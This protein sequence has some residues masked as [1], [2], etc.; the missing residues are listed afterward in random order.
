MADEKQPLI[1]LEDDFQKEISK[2]NKRREEAKGPYDALKQ[3]IDKLRAALSEKERKMVEYLAILNDRRAEHRYDQYKAQKL[4]EIKEDKKTQVISTKETLR[5]W[6]TWIKPRHMASPAVRN[7]EKWLMD[8]VSYI[9]N[10]RVI[11]VHSICRH[12]YYVQYQHK[13]GTLHMIDP[14]LHGYTK[15]RRKQLGPPP[16]SD[17]NC[18]LWLCLQYPDVIRWKRWARVVY[19]A[20]NNCLSHRRAEIRERLLSHHRLDELF[21]NLYR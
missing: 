10:I 20:Q 14:N 6:I 21:G 15:G 17:S 1:S 13:D 8:I 11:P 2:E 4:K 16:V 19:L 3:E 18:L 5:S 12:Q 9:Q 7:A